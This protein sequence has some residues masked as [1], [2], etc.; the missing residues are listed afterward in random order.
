MLAVARDRGLPVVHASI[1]D[2]PFPDNSFDVTYSFKVLPH[3]E[4]IERALAE[5][6]RVTRPG[7]YVLA[8]FYNPWSLRYLV[9]RL[10]RPTHISNAAHDEH[11]YTRYDSLAEVKR[12][13]PPSLSVVD[14]RGV[15]VVTPVSQVHSIP[16]L[17]DAFGKLERLAADAPVLRRLGGFLIVVA[18]KA[19]QK[20]G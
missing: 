18:Q 20:S 17:G 14:L 7:G 11:V 12:Y 19:A 1:T 3:V 8:E 2:I 6:A 4:H 9:K 15:R 10:K 16:V 5:M 13:L